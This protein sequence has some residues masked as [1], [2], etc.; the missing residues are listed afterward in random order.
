MLQA[1]QGRWREAR[2]NLERAVAENPAL[3]AAW[4]NLGIFRE[5]Y[6]GEAGRARECYEKY[7]KLRGSRKEEVR[8]WAERLGQA[9]SSRQ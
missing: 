4:L 8:S 3:A 6:E 2:E 1:E 5:V 7:V 9:S